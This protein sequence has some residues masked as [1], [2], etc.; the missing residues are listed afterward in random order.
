[1]EQEQVYDLLDLKYHNADMF[2]RVVSE[3]PVDKVNQL[4][5]SNRAFHHLCRKK[6]FWKSL[7]FQKL[8]IPVEDLSLAFL[9]SQYLKYASMLDL[10][11]YIQK[12]SEDWK[13]FQGTE[14]EIFEEL[15][16]ISPYD[17]QNVRAK[18]NILINT[19]FNH[20][21]EKNNLDC[22]FFAVQKGYQLRNST[23]MF[24]REATASKFMPIATEGLHNGN[25]FDRLFSLLD[26]KRTI[27]FLE[28]L[29][30]NDLIE[31]PSEKDDCQADLIEKVYEEKWEK[32][33]ESAYFSF[34]LF[35]FFFSPI[36]V[37]ASEK[38][39]LKLFDFSMDKIMT[40]GERDR[41]EVISHLVSDLMTAKSSYLDRF[42]HK[43]KA[44]NAKEIAEGK[45]DFKRTS[46]KE[47]DD[48]SEEKKP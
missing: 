48:E 3:M 35:H 11:K 42:V 37:K 20:G 46:R 21:L 33:Q 14:K 19:F 13:D 29:T 36:L 18:Q 41:K 8:P 22:L 40:L 25:L 10:A 31:L 45:K 27:L 47:S 1:M 34:E 32:F 2:Y 17:D 4:C 12:H 44:S 24:A 39:C 43:F 9:R 16:R 7:W 5:F 38:R 15:L 30:L 28:N 23:F 6:D 26:K